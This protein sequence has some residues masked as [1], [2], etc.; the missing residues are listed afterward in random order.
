[1]I[2]IWALF[3]LCGVGLH[4]G[5]IDYERRLIPIAAGPTPGAFGTIWATNTMAVGESS[6]EIEIVGVLPTRIPPGYGHSYPGNVALPTSVNEPPGTIL[7]IPG[8]ASGALH[9]SA[10]LEERQ[11]T[12]TATQLPVVKEHEF[13]ART[14]YFLHLEKR[15]GARIHLRVYSLDLSH[16]APNVRI[17]IQANTLPSSNPWIF[18]YDSVHTLS[19]KQQTMTDVAGTITV[20]IRPLAIELPLDALLRDVPDGVEL[21]VSVV[22]AS[23]DLKIWAMVSETDNASQRVSLRTPD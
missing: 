13:L 19:A 8:D 23:E 2:R 4:A 16:V 18:V 5:A 17:R 11:L 7:Y 3:L 14:R 21:A 9:I 10:E 6:T 15:A 12:G 1:M 22:P 20:A